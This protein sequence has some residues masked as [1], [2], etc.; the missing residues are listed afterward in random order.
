MDWPK[1]PADRYSLPGEARKICKGSQIFQESWRQRQA[2]VCNAQQSEQYEIMVL[3][4]SNTTR[5]PFLVSGTHAEQ[6]EVAYGLQ[7]KK[8][9]VQSYS[10]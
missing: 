10:S 6:A 1:K 2:S 3:C 7:K 5:I 9:T 4:L 8:G